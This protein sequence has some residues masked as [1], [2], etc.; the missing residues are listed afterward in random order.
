M[1]R[2]VEPDLARLAE[3]HGVAT[4]YEDQQH[5]TV[6]VGR[7]SVVATLAALD[8]D[9]STPAAVTAALAEARLA[10]YRR[11]L[12]PTVVVRQGVGAAVEL[13][14][15]DDADP[16]VR[17]VLEDG[18]RAGGLTWR[19]VYV[20]PVEVDGRRVGSR[21]LVL[22]P[23]LPLGYHRLDASAG[24]QVAR[25][26]VIVAPDRLV[27]PQQLTRAWGWTLQLYAVRSQK[28]WG[29]GDFADLADIAGWSA[30]EG[31]GFVLCN[32]LHAVSP[33]PPLQPSPYYPASRR[34]A[35]AVYL[36]VEATEEYAAAPAD[37]RHRIDALA[38]QQQAHNRDDRIDRDG[39]WAAKLEA[40]RL[41]WDR[42][43]R[44]AE[45][46][47]EFRRR[48]GEGLEAFATW[49]A[50]A[51]ENGSDWQQWP[52]ELRHPGG[53][54]VAAA[55]RRLRDRVDFHAWLQL[56]C[57]QQLTE[58]EDAAERGGMPVGVVHDLPVGVDPGG[59]DAWALQDV[60]A[61]TTTVGAPPDAFNQQGQGWGLPPWRPDRL[62]EAGYRPYRDLLR[63]V[64]RHA[65]GLRIDHI[66]GLFRLWW[67]PA[68]LRP[69]QGT[70]VRYDA[71]A[72]LGVLTLEAHRTSALVIGED[73]GTVER[74]V[75][76]ELA[77][78]GI[79]GSAVLWFERSVDPET[80][81]EDGRRPLDEWR[82]LAL[83]SITTHDLPTAAG[84][85]AGEHV[86]VRD[87]LHQLTRP[88]EEE[89][90]SAAEELAELRDLLRAERLIGADP[91][92]DE[93]LLAMHEALTR[94]PCRLVAVAPGDAAGDLRQPNLPGTVDEYP[95]W[96]LPVAD[97]AGV[98]LTLEDLRRHPGVRRVIA[99]MQ[100]HL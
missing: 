64:L 61:V 14:P 11:L 67:V 22:P 97:A 71:D 72:L 28:S 91:A 53:P 38:E 79:L 9:A 30:G 1:T 31:A 15:V 59:A 41:L 78:R 19:P 35:N 77:D 70:Y 65:G 96:R 98:P 34:F 88:V 7:D 13:H 57:E 50:L 74:R 63:A 84:F 24:E 81:E 99:L 4:E 62:A 32:P 43:P 3:L 58:A 69:A 21:T 33:V 76:R 18:S 40:L 86:R 85:L 16:T 20:V 55:R 5:R 75:Q 8:V 39:A 6:L 68:G 45:A 90:A 17:L 42:A 73:L 66:L 36:R 10:A 56:L 46:L 51:E 44:A 82:E 37:V 48:E 100:E 12:P 29:I 26:T 54:A 27:L 49:C 23:G 89:R 83:A 93:L 80:G 60:L 47:A 87:E 25:A 94:T 2:P 92:G 95:N 52:D